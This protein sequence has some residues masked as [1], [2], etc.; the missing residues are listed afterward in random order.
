MSGASPG[1]RS[2]CVLVTGGSGFV[3]RSV[4]EELQRRD[5]PVIATHIEPPDTL[6]VG[7]ALTWV[8]WDIKS[9][10]LPAVD[11]RDVD[12]ILHLAVPTD[13]FAF[14]AQART[15]FDLAVT[16]TFD[17]LEAARNNG[18]RRVLL[19]STGDVLGASGRAACEEDT[20]YQPTSF[21]GTTKACAELLA[22]SYER[23]LST[24]VLRFYHP[25]G[26]GGKRFLVNRMIE[27]VR[28]EREISIE[29]ENGITLNPVWAED[30]AR[31]IC[32][33]IESSEQG[34]FHFGGPDTVTLRE[35]AER[36]GHVVRKAPRIVAGATAGVERHAGSYERSRTL[37]GYAPAMPLDE[38]LRRLHE[39]ATGR[40]MNI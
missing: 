6:P 17:L 14:P 29:G 9:G 12:A 36:I 28:Q 25:Y 8:P 24:A 26:P 27:L 37:L 31:G 34:I 4:L 16:A 15:L 33:A 5:R 22:R 21:Y 40:E 7:P 3:G 38:G 1:L 18:V 11:W 13:L 19:A 2:R 32:Q 39:T 23:V 20:H 35:L 10:R 30:L